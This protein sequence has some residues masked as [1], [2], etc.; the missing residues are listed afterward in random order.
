MPD[1]SPAAAPGTFLRPGDRLPSLS[2]AAAPDGQV[3]SLRPS[4]RDALLVL[5]LQSP[6]GA[7]SRDY[8]RGLADGDAAFRRWDARPIAVLPAD[9]DAAANLVRDLQPPFA[10][11][12]DPDGAARRRCGVDDGTAALFVADRWGEVYY[13]VR[14]PSESGLPAPQPPGII[15]QWVRY[16]ATQCPEC[17][18]PDEPG[19]GEWAR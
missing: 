18:V 11:L 17:G 19:Q 1:R 13:S 3:V 8:L 5:F 10:L 6:D 7:E 14:A 2:L 4:G 16:I 12:A 15:M 9:L